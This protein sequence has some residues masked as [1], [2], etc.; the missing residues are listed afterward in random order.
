MEIKNPIY[1]WSG[2]HYSFFFNNV[3]KSINKYW[4]HFPKS[5]FS[6]LKQTDD[7]SVVS[8]KRTGCNKQTG[9]SKN[10]I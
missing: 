4:D 6:K 8:I 3:L 7:Y 9:W 1:V 5:I 2:T 10:L